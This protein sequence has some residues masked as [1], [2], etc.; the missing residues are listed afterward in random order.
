MQVQAAWSST[1]LQTA[2]TPQGEGSH[3]FSSSMNPTT[4]EHI[5]KGL[6][7]CACEHMQLMT[8]FLVTHWALIPQLSRHGSTHFCCLQISLFLH[9]SCRTHWGPQLGG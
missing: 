4:G 8:W 6:P 7:V 3:G 2:L 9:W 5:S 1:T